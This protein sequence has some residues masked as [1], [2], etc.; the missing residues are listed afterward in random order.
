MEIN[1]LLKKIR[2]KNHLTQRGLGEILGISNQMVSKIENSKIEI[3]AKLI[4]KIIEQFPDEFSSDIKSKKQYSKKELNDFE[5]EI[6]ETYELIRNENNYFAKISSINRILIELN[7]DLEEKVIKLETLIS[8]KDSFLIK[9]RI[10]NPLKTTIKNLKNYQSRLEN[11]L[12]DNSI[13]KIEE[14]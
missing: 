10:K 13:I 4:K 3:S 9:N 11:I 6:L 7:K 2:K 1:I 8:D 14:E 12:E 5:K